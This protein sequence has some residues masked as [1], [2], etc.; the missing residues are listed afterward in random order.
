MSVDPDGDDDGSL[1]AGGPVACNLSG[2]LS[3]HRGTCSDLRTFK[4]DSLEGLVTECI[5]PDTIFLPPGS[6]VGVGVEVDRPHPQ[7]SVAH[8]Y[9][10]DREIVASPTPI[11]RPP[12][13]ES[14][15]EWVY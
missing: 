9:C 3:L 13:E 11:E 10:V 2:G 4:H 12:S 15:P 7:T 14:T 6:L 5:L 1:Q 8:R